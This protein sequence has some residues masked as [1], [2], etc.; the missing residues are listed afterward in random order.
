MESLRSKLELWADTVGL[1][2]A[3]AE[4]DLEPVD[5][6]IHLYHCGLIKLPDWLDFEKEILEDEDEG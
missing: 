6:L 4:N 2:E 3:L 5:A 1:E